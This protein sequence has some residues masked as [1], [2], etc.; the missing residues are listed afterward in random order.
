MKHLYTAPN[1]DL[2]YDISLRIAS[3]LPVRDVCALGSCSKFW[4]ELCESDQLWVSLTTQ[5]WPSLH[6]S[7]NSPIPD[8]SIAQPS[9]ATGGWKAFYVRRH[10]E[11]GS[12][13]LK[14]VERCSF[15][16]SLEVQDYRKA[17]DELCSMQLDFMDVQMFLFKPELNVMLNLV[18]L[19]YGINWLGVPL[20]YILD[21][22]KGSNISERQV[23][24]KWWKVGRWSRGFRLRDEAHHHV[25]SL[26]DLATEK[27]DLLV[28]LCRGA[29][30]EVIRVQIAVAYPLNVPWTCQNSVLSGFERS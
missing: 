30:Y 4:R 26:A 3:F 11:M 13:V 28:V 18:G 10:L 9:S 7:H 15:S 19:H 22:L 23:S 21:S 1:F 8:Y 20:Q 29:V 25:V 17:I 16:V 14:F 24:I 27:Q 6:L 2:P 12:K 5:R